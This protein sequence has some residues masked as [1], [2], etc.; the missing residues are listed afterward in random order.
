[1]ML[2]SLL[3]ILVILY[4]ALE[5][6]QR[7]RLK[8]GLENI[9]DSNALILLGDSVINNANY[10]PADKSVVFLI[11]EKIPKTYNFAADGALIKNLYGQ[12]DR[13]PADLLLNKKTTTAVISAGGNDILEATQ[14]ADLHKLA[15]ELMDFLKAFKTKFPQITNI[16][17]L[18]LYQPANPKFES[19]STIITKWNDILE[20]GAA[21]QIVPYKVGDIYA[22]VSGPE[23]FV[24]GYEP[25]IPGGQKIATLITRM[26]A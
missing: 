8:E 21:N 9:A 15:D 14:P 6:M 16:N 7:Q 24:Y 25:S 10:V 11:K 12:L 26:P 19:Y 18:N 5:F 13:I 4:F 20:K 3:A 1:M 2:F 22:L 23:D 17:I